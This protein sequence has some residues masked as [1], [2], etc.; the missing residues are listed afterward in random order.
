MSLRSAAPAISRRNIAKFFLLALS[1]SFWLLPGCSVISN[2]K[3]VFEGTSMLPGLKN[4]DTLVISRFDRGAKFAVQ[5]GDIILFLFPDD[6]SK[7]YIKRLIGL[8]GETVEIRE[9]KVFIN[10]I[11]LE[12]PYVAT[13]LNTASRS[14]PPVK[15][16]EHHY[17]ILGDNRDN[18][19]DSRIWGLA[20][21]KY[22][23]GRV[24]DR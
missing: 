1:S 23:L 9:G 16:Q 22:V 12:E 3:V 14:L 19:S 4:G 7:F 8:P 15:V 6:P 11:A 13:R 18:S 21:E 24:I 20:P 10:G 17:Y 5:R 2:H